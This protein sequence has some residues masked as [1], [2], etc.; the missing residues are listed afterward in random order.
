VKRSSFIKSLG[1]IV[2]SGMIIPDANVKKL[3]LPKH[4]SNTDTNIGLE[5][6]RITSSGNVLLGTNITDTKYKLV[7]S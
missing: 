5:H 4:T 2:G 7:I 3:S 1:I 6:M